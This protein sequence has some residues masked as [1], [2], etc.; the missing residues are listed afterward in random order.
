M[1]RGTRTD[2]MYHHQTQSRSVSHLLFFNTSSTM[3]TDARTKA[4]NYTNVV[5]ATGHC[6]MSV[7]FQGVDYCRNVFSGTL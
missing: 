5:R 4:V 2:S 1:P 7:G 6:D 3:S